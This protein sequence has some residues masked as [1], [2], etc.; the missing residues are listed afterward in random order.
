[1]YL[2]HLNHGVTNLAPRALPRQ[3]SHNVTLIATNE[4]LK[5]LG[6]CQASLFLW[7][8]TKDLFVK[9]IDKV[10]L[11]SIQL[12][13]YETRIRKIDVE[14]Y[15]RIEMP[16]RSAVWTCTSLP[17]LPLPVEKAEL[18]KQAMQALL[19]EQ[20]R[21][22][23]RICLAP[24]WDNQSMSRERARGC[25]VWKTWYHCIISDPLTSNYSAPCSRTSYGSRFGPHWPKCTKF[26]SRATFVESAP[27]S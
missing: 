6:A 20:H 1:M 12:S 17:S 9:I 11:S 15:V 25:E 22:P 27:C 16:C 2:P 26:V 3:V 8:E 4:M 18:A 21:P 24:R 13:I 14:L 10:R 7:P 19:S 5:M 23:K